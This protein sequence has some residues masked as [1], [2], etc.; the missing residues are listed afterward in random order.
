LI[1]GCVGEIF[2]C[3]ANTT[4]D[5]SLYAISSTK[6]VKLAPPTNI[7]AATGFPYTSISA[8]CSL[9]NNNTTNNT[10]NNNNNNSSSSSSSNNNNTPLADA[11]QKA[12]QQTTNIKQ[13]FLAKSI[14]D[15][16]DDAIVYMSA[17]CSSMLLGL[18]VGE[19]KRLL[20]PVATV[21]ST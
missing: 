18:S 19:L 20:L 16:G 13:V 10:T 9:L 15:L 4:A 2:L 3:I 11:K 7:A 8:F 1:A 6:S 14:V 12:I 21:I 5:I 17:G